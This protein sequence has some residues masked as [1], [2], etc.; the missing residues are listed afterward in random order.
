MNARDE[1][2]F[3]AKFIFLNFGTFSHGARLAIRG[4]KAR[5]GRDKSVTIIAS[6]P[7]KGRKHEFSI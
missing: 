6:Q 7:K 5:D 4:L 2:R 3:P 1:K